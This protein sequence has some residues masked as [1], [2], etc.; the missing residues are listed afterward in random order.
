M[1]IHLHLSGEHIT[2]LLVLAD[3]RMDLPEGL[4]LLLPLNWMLLGLVLVHIPWLDAAPPDV[5]LVLAQLA[6]PA[7][8][9]GVNLYDVGLDL[10]LRTECRT[11][12]LPPGAGVADEGVHRVG[13]PLSFTSLTETLAAEFTLE[14][15]YLLV[16]SLDVNLQVLLPGF[17]SH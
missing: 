11:A 3:E 5:E 10:A 8:L 16:H 12:A 1:P 6:L 7:P 4:L 2:A 15:F 17:Q 14:S 13:V 9:L